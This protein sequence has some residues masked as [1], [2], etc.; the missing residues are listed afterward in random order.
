MIFDDLYDSTRE[1]KYKICQKIGIDYNGRNILFSVNGVEIK[2]G[3]NTLS[4]LWNDLML[5]D[6]KV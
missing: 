1:I 3:Y 6:V 4:E 5:N 2:R